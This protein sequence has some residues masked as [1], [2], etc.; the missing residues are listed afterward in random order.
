MSWRR[1]HNTKKLTDKKRTYCAKHTNTPKQ[2][3]EAINILSNMRT[4]IYQRIYCMIT[5]PVETWKQFDFLSSESKITSFIEKLEK[6]I[7]AVKS[8]NFNFSKYK[9]AIFC[10]LGKDVEKFAEPIIKN[11][12]IAK[13]QNIVFLIEETVDN[14]GIKEV[15]NTNKDIMR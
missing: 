15:K 4:N 10:I 6:E 5:S 8:D 9:I 1:T 7:K 12:Y 14:E 13:F 2:T 11:M 3:K